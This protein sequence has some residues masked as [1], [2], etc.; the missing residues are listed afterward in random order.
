[1]NIAI[2]GTRGIPNRYGGFEECAQEISWRMVAREHHVTVYS[3]DGNSYGK[4]S[5]QGVRIRRT[6][7]KEDCFGI[8]GTFLFD[9]LCLR[10]A[11]KQDY[12]IILELGYVPSSFFFRIKKKTNA[13]L[14]TNMDGMEWKRS[15]WNRIIKP[16]V[17]KC[18]RNGAKYSDA[19]VADNVGIQ[20]YL[21]IHYGESATLIPYGAK[22][23]DEISDEVLADYQLRP[24]SFHMLVARLEPENN[25]EMILDGAVQSSAH[26]P[27]LVI[28]DH[29]TRYGNHLKKRYRDSDFIKFMGGIYDYEKLTGLRKNSRLYFHGHS[30]GGTNP[31]LLEA[32]ASE[33]RICVHD[34]PFNRAIMGSDC[35]Y[36]SSPDHVARLIDSVNPVDQMWTER[37]ASHREKLES[38]Y[39]WDRITT[40]YLELFESL[41]QVPE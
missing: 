34:N 38:I 41:L 7:C 28:G 26:L 6:F 20:D 21:S 24:M 10:D 25:I 8:F 17:R 3:P 29:G 30:V 37:I 18:E 32:M 16:F 39:N 36:F 5:W 23:L 35:D 4:D 15:K 14:V 33:A 1:M 2:L 11:C 31:S 27:F 12:D 40:Q 19:M 13:K 9:Y 22:I